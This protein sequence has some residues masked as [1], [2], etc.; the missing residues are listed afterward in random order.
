MTRATPQRFTGCAGRFDDKNQCV[1]IVESMTTC[2]HCCVEAYGVIDVLKV[3]ASFPVFASI[4]TDEA[5]VFAKE[6]CV[7]R[8]RA[9]AGQGFYR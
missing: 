8:P 2:D 1:T 3:S 7:Q 9:P 5:G 4:L 6:I